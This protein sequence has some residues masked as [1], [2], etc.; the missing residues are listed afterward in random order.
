MGWNQLHIKRRAPH[1]EG[2]PDVLLYTLSIRFFPGL[3]IPEII[4]TT[5]DYGGTE[6]VSSVGSGMSSPPNFTRRKAR[7]LVFAFWPISANWSSQ[8]PN[9]QHPI[10]NTPSDMLVFLPLTSK[11]ADVYAS[12]KAIWTA[13][14]IL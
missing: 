9:T 2:V 1:L 7:I 3:T 10:P 8:P 13:H 5:T 12:I 11:A 6:F 14:S 4:A